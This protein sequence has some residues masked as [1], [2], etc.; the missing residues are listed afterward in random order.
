MQAV[1]SNARHP[2]YGE[3]IILFPI[4]GNEYDHCLELLEALGIGD[5]VERDCFI[6]EMRQGPPVL[7]RLTGCNVTL[8]ELDYLAKRLD[9]FDDQE[10]AKFQGAAVSCNCHGIVD[11]INL[12]FSCQQVTIITDFTDL[13]EIG[14]THYMDLN[15][16]TARLED[17]ASL[18]GRKMALDLIEGGDGRITPYGVVYENGMKLTQIYDGRRFPEYFYESC[19]ASVILSLPDRPMERETLYF[20]CAESKIARTLRRLGVEQPEQC[21]AMLDTDEIAAAV[22]GVFESEYPL[23]EHLYTLNALT[24]CLQKFDGQAL[25]DFHTVFDTV[26][27]ET[28]E[29]VLCLAENLHDFAV[30]PDISSAE[31][32]GWFLIEKSEN[33]AVDPKLEDCVDYQKYGQHRIQEEGGRFGDRGYVAYLGTK[34][35]IRS[36]MDRNLSERQMNQ[37]QSQKKNT[38]ME[39]GGGRL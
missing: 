4:P 20:P 27:P 21:M 2:E 9:S 6:R 38:S 32:Y 36:I 15:G 24:R 17:L 14:Q 16:G 29:E 31:E 5:P 34:P 12:T 10:M 13:E 18:D 26:W 30:V 7:K 39:M 22:R 35:E 28:P 11:L 23:N 37:S 3:A 8:D 19:L 1:L 33:L 25:E